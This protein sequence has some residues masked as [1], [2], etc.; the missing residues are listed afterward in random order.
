MG[1]E[2]LH[3]EK[4]R[5]CYTDTIK[6]LNRNTGRNR[7]TLFYITSSFH[8]THMVNIGQLYSHLFQCMGR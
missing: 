2:I 5:S 7:R 8:M 6:I 1:L 3:Q 4:Q